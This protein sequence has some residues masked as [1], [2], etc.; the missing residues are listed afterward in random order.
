MSISCEI[1]LEGAQTHGLELSNMCKQNKL[2]EAHAPRSVASVLPL[3]CGLD[4]TCG[5]VVRAVPK[6][7]RATLHHSRQ[8]SDLYINAWEWRNATIH[9]GDYYY[10][11]LLLYSSH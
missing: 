11:Y 8:R 9:A 7:Y 6:R 1:E 2:A 5:L 10:Y 4:R 3:P